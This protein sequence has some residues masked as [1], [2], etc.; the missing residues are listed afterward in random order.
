MQ[1]MSTTG[2]RPLATYTQAMRR[3]DLSERI[4]RW[5]RYRLIV[6]LKRSRHAPDYVARSVAIGVFW[7]L[8]PTVGIQMALVMLHWLLVGRLGRWDFN[9]IHAMAWTW[10][11]N[12]FTVLPFY[13]LFYVS[14]Q[15][16][17]GRWHD[18]TGYHGFL[19]LWETTP[20]PAPVAARAAPA[21]W[22]GQVWA[23]LSDSVLAVIAAGEAFFEVVVAGLGV[24]M[25]VGCL[26]WA[27]VGTWLSYRWS[28]GL[29][30]HHRRHRLDRRY[31]RAHA[32][33]GG[34]DGARPAA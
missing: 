26:P 15:V 4:R 6:P 19:R 9:A 10:V 20:T 21:D 2:E 13:Y 25:L 24:T 5:L 28:L 8:T 16:L 23:Y 30:I 29:V 12:V 7:A 27:V 32:S 14:G 17:L 22:W 31:A 11:T 34:K 1:Q 18:L 33:E 3:R